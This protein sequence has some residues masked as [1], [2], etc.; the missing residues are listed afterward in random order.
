[1]K[2]VPRSRLAA[3]FT[4]PLALLSAAPSVQWCSIEWCV[5]PVA[6]AQCETTGSCAATDM[7]CAFAMP[8]CAALAQAACEAARES[9]DPS[10]CEPIAS[11]RMFCV[12][13]PMGGV[14]LRPAL[15]ADSPLE[16]IHAIAAAALDLYAAAAPSH[17]V[18]TAARARAPAAPRALRPPARAPPLA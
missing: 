10:S 8:E 1:M 15:D 5:T 7:Q 6:L 9:G 13:G 3:L 2:A 12:G 16:P 17:P 18:A 4:L 11:H 14:G